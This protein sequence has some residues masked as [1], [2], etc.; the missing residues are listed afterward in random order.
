MDKLLCCSECKSDDIEFQIWADEND[1][2][3]SIVEPTV[4]YCNNCKEQTSCEAKDKQ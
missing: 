4:V 2:A 1:V 3:T